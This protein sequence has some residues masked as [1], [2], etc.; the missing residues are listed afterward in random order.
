MFKRLT[1]RLKSLAAVSLLAL[2]MG[3]TA[4]ETYRNPII[5]ADVPDMSLCRVG[6]YYYLISTTM[7]LM[8]GAPIMRS[9]DMKNWET[10]SYVFDKINDG[11][12]YDLKDNKTVYGQGQWASSI[13]Y[14]NGKFYVWF[15]ANGAPGKGFIYTADKAEGPWKLIQ[16]PRHLHDGSLFFDDD[17]RVYI[18]C[19]TGHLVELNE[20]LSDVKEGG[21]DMILFERDAEEQG[22]LLEGSSVFKHNGKYYLCMISMKWGVPNRYR[23]EVC[24]RADKITGPYEKKVLI[25][26]PF[27]MYGGV[28]QGCLVDNADGSWSS[29]IFQDRDGIGRTPCLLP[30]R[31]EDGWPML[32]DA[33]GKV[34][35]DYSKPY[36][37]M[38]GITSSD[39]FDGNG[40]IYGYAGEQECKLKLCWQWNHNPIDTFTDQNGKTENAW[41]ITERPDFLRLRTARLADNIFNAPNTLTQR[42][43]GP[44]C[45][46]AIKMD[47]SNM[48]DGDRA[49]ISGFQSD[50][51][52][53]SVKKDNGSCRIVLTKESMKL[54]RG[55]RVIDHVDAEEVMSIDI[56]TNIVYLRVYADFH[57]MHD[58][59]W[60]E[61]SLDGENWTRIGDEIPVKFDYTRFFMGTKFAIFNYATQNLGGYVDVDWFHYEADLR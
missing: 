60:Y 46:G 48:K 28:G 9:T 38:E 43:T 55:N 7:H 59:S 52:V 10:I 39:E 40:K 27:E 12:R 47:I 32:G 3:C 33:E 8:P 16:R 6:D 4:Q 42:M 44:K 56:N 14:H 23:R 29:L 24:Y 22:A 15:T 35:N 26:T 21:T 19:E 2:T 53:L 58:I 31:W 5:N 45:N 1:Q 18:F 20:D 51:G 54:Q 11:D 13:R 57:E 25:E 61:Y 17:N 49:G 50:C 34:P 30:V 37:S 41:S 36:Q